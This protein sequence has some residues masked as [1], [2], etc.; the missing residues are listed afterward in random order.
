MK[1][2]IIESIKRFACV[3]KNTTETLRW[4]VW[5][6]ICT[7]HKN[8]ISKIN[9]ISTLTILANG[10]SLIKDLEE[11]DLGAGDFC[12]VNDFY[13]SPWYKKIKPSHHVLADP[14]YFTK[15]EDLRPFIEAVN[16]DM[17]LYVPY[18]AWKSMGLLRNIPSRHMEVVP[19][20]T[21]YY[22]GFEQLRTWIFKHG[23][24]MPVPQNVLA[25]SIFN[26]INMGYKEIRLYGVD[27]SWTESI[28]VDD[29][30][31]V[32]FTD[33]HF[34]DNEQVKLLP[35]KKCSGEQYKMHEILRDLAQMFDS[36]HQ[37]RKYSDYRK[38]RIVN[39]TKHSYIDA[40]ERS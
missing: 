12:V 32:C 2:L 26:A 35:W 15:D 6:V 19:Y 36:Y 24:A 40:F 21:Y 22:N 27:H 11:I 16:W 14:L 8:H 20:H 1:K 33:S 23:F 17:K 7:D 31:R 39:Y 13:K 34:F 30:N 5:F 37:I 10:P 9:D 3:C 29:M 18:Y 4:L 38:C 28:R 25:P